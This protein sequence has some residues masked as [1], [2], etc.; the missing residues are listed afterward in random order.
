MKMSSLDT[1][2]QTQSTLEQDVLALVHRLSTVRDV[3]EIMDIVRHGARSLLGA[4][5]VT[6]V[7]RDGDYCYYAEEDA[8]SPLWKG[9]RFPLTS[10]ISGWAMLNHQTAVI[11]DIYED[12]RIPHDAYRLTFV[13]SLV[14]VPVRREDPAAAIGAYWKERRQPHPEEVKLLETIANAAA[15]AMTNV[16]LIHSLHGM[17]EELQQRNQELDLAYRARAS[18]LTTMSHELRTPL[19]VILGYAEIM[20]RQ[21]NGAMSPEKCSGY[22]AEIQT[23]GKKLLEMINDVLDLAALGSG[24][25]ALEMKAVSLG[26]IIDTA[27]HLMSSPLQKNELTLTNY[28]SKTLPPLKG[29][30]RLLK[31]IFFNILSNSVKFT[32]PGGSIT[33]AAETLPDGL[34]CSITDTGIGMTEEEI[35]RA[36]RPFQQV[37]ERLERRYDG[38]GLG[39]ALCKGYVDLHGGALNIESTPGKGTTV[40]VTL[41]LLSA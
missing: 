40:T 13:H 41:P 22:A 14:M 4:D 11:K 20:Q 37:D 12:P 23:A 31:Q 3:Q 25:Y 32:P 16:G 10:C 6:F 21:I 19:N 9:M 7:L 39:L 1:D 27:T 28:I 29:D 15:V 18:F 36:I 34:A 5:G 35:K 17:V 24:T 2:T 33:I 38:A 26:A 30:P 8:I